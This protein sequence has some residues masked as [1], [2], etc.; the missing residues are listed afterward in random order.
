MIFNMS[1]GGA[2]MN[3]KVVGGTTAPSN[4]KEN[5][6]WINTATPITSYVFSATEPS[7]AEE[8][9]V[10]I[11]V[12][13]ASN[14]AFSATKKNPIM[15]YPLYAKQSVSGAWASV[16][17]MSY[18]E[19]WKEWSRYLVSA[20][21]IAPELGEMIIRADIGVSMSITNRSGGGITI[22]RT[23]GNA[24]FVS[25]FSENKIDVSEFKT[26]RI[27]TGNVNYGDQIFIGLHVSNSAVQS[28]YTR[29]MNVSAGT[30]NKLDISDLNGGYYLAFGFGVYGY[31]QEAEILEITLEY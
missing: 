19:G 23:S 21:G 27:K 14:V 8:G 26:M 2:T 9:M 4:P 13:A 22:K 20:A 17:A 25:A 6:I 1:G 30:D 29:V 5:T 24:G 15:V 10:W 16:S 28:A 18:Q 12:G 3:F 11:S 7:S 31:I